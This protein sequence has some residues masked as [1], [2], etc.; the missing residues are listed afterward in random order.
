M[1]GSR[2]M[3]FPVLLAAMALGCGERAAAPTANE[4]ATTVRKSVQ[5]VADRVVKAPRSASIELTMLLESLEAHAKQQGGE[6]EEL[7][8]LAQEVKGKLG[9]KPTPQQVEAEF[10]KLTSKA[11]T[12]Q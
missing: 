1:S 4:T 3:L 8:A 5:S 7:F 2:L 6:Y 9:D 10:G 12:L 11:A